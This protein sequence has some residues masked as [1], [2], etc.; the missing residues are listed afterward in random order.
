MTFFIVKRTSDGKTDNIT[1]Y[2]FK[3]GKFV[4]ENG[5]Y[6]YDTVEYFAGVPSTILKELL[7]EKPKKAKQE[8]V[9]E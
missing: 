9:T 1:E 7:A 6:T 5:E 4:G 3:T 2:N 8:E